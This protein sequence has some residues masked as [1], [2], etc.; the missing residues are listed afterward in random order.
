MVPILARVRTY[1]LFVFTV[2]NHWR[3]VRRRVEYTWTMD[4]KFSLTTSPVLTPQLKALLL[5][6]LI[7]A[8]TS[9][10]WTQAIQPPN[11]MRQEFMFV[12]PTVNNNN[13]TEVSI[14]RGRGT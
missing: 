11:Y 5:M 7:N 9:D 2:I 8:I 12:P 3:R 10:P 6:Y 13:R 4:P 14:H 1:R